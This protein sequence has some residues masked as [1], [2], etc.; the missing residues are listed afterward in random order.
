MKRWLLLFPLIGIFSGCQTFQTTQQRQAYARRQAANQQNEEQIR[1]LRGRVES[2]E[3]E[4]ARL[5][6]EVQ[7]L[8]I[9]IR[10]ANSNINQLNRSM[11]SLDAKQKRE[12]QELIHRVEILLKKRL[13]STSSHT[14]S[15]ASSHRG[16]GRIH[17]VEPGHTLSAIATAY[18]TTVSA[19]KKANHLK[20]DNIRV[21]Q[22][23]FIPE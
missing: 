7:Q 14:A 22:K 9:D 3:M 4:N 23:L 5:L 10:T 8:R 2:I 12:M 18:G 21:G 1:R 20:S 13:A 19:I 11:Q 16:S 17:I 6:R 15:G